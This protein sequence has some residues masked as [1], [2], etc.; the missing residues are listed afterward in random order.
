MSVSSTHCAARLYLGFFP[1]ASTRIC[2]TIR[3]SA[4]LSPLCELGLWNVVLGIPCRPQSFPVATWVV[5]LS[6]QRFPKLLLFLL[7][8]PIHLFLVLLMMSI[9]LYHFTERSWQP[10]Q[11]PWMSPLLDGTS[12]ITVLPELQ[13][14][15]WSLSNKTVLLLTI[16][17]A[18]TKHIKNGKA[19]FASQSKRT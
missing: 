9:P 8:S 10:S 15:S 4:F 7:C 16:S 6:W 3:G 11:P 12:N 14:I 19:H 17:I 5:C 1:C 18:F 13:T 2:K